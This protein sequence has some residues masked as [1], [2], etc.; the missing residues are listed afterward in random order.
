MKKEVSLVDRP[1]KLAGYDIE[2]Y[3]A[4][5]GNLS[6]Y[7]FVTSMPQLVFVVTGWKSN[8]K[9]NACLHSW[10]SFMGSG[11][12]DFI[13]ILGKVNKDGHMYQSLKETKVCVLNFPSNDSYDRCV[14][15][16]KNNQFETDEIT[17]SGLTTEKATTI[18]APRIKECF[19]NI[20]CEYL[21]EQELFE[22]SKEVAIAVRAVN[23]CMDSE[24]YDQ[25]KRGRYGNNGYL[26]YIDQPTNPETGEITPVGPGIVE[27]S[28]PI[29]WSGN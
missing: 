28:E 24:S 12:E 21:W 7:D 22:G 13:C 5:C 3:V 26:Y 4:F 29:E 9:E 25:T 19:L 15:T 16:I 18:D 27:P 20:E 17:A 14:Q 8:G 2:Q 23:I 1:D 6:W 11:L 10:S